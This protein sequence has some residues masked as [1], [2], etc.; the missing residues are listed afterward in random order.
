M[1]KSLRTLVLMSM[2]AAMSYMLMF[3]LQI[4]LI[5]A[6]PYLKYDPSD[7]PTLIGGFVL[8]P[9]AAV[10]ISGV[11]ALLYMI[12]KGESGPV[13]SI[14]NFLASASFAFTAAMIYKKRPGLLTAGLGMLAGA[15]VMTVIMY[16]SN[17]LWAL[18][19]YGIPKAAH[20]G[21]LRTAVTP[22]NLARGAMSTLITFPVFVALIPALKKLGFTQKNKFGN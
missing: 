9:V 16:F 14:Q 5:P 22:F 4:P 11:K 15:L 21:L 12:T 3:T 13:G 17:A 10:V 7:V 18:S 2:F 8:G 1:N 20:A 6:A 19:A